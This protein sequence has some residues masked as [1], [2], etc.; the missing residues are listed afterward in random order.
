M[1]DFKS[2]PLGE[3]V[4]ANEIGEQEQSLLSNYPNFNVEIKDG[5]MC[6]SPSEAGVA[7]FSYIKLVNQDKIEAE[8]QTA[9]KE[10]EIIDLTETNYTLR[11]TCEYMIEYFE[12]IDTP[13]AQAMHERL[14]RVVYPVRAFNTDGEEVKFQGEQY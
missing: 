1:E 2:T 12:S 5:V 10:K 4:A 13:E 6:I 7:I 3:W 9:L 11:D 8:E 14:L